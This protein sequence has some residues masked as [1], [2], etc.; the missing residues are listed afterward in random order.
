MPSLSLSFALHTFY[1]I[2]IPNAAGC[3]PIRLSLAV[4][5]AWRTS[6]F[7]EGLNESIPGAN[8]V[9][10]PFFVFLPL[11]VRAS[12]ESGSFD[13]ASRSPDFACGNLKQ[14]ASRSND[15][16]AAAL[17]QCLVSGGQPSL[18]YVRN[19]VAVAGPRI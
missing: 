13:M 17:L 16:A 6:Q 3:A 5:S 7:K 9:A 18:I 10:V 19:Y 15:D 14:L 8:Q 11:A 1:R 2:H 4:R 12:T